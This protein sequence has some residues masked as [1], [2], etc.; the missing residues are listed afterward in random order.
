MGEIKTLE[1]LLLLED[2]FTLKGEVFAGEGETCGEV[3]FNTSMAGYQEAITDP[4][5]HGQILTFTYPH[6]GNYGCNPYDNE[7]AIPQVKG[8]L[9]KRHCHLPDHPLSEEKLGDFLDR[10]GV[11]GVEGIDTRTLTLHLRRF[12]AMKGIIATGNTNKEELSKKLAE[13]PSIVGKNL[14]QNVTTSSPYYRPYYW[15]SSSIK[16]EWEI[17]PTPK[18]SGTNHVVVVDLGVKYSILTALAE[19]G[20]RVTVVPAT[21]P[22]EEIKAMDPSGILFSNGPGDPAPL[23]YITST[24]RSL[25]GWRPIMGI[26]LGHQVI[27]RTLGM[28]SFKLTFGHRGVNHPVKDLQSGRVLITVQNH[29]FNLAYNKDEDLPEGTTATHVNLNDNTLE[30]IENLN[31]GLFS[32]Q[33]HPEAGPGPH[34]CKNLFDKFM[35]ML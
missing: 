5:Y 14:V 30:G 31:W 24:V 35:E 7:S 16:P 13:Y 10:H 4:S 25:L 15:S 6:I 8:V 17:T 21:T 32:V 34:D 18:E 1:A 3:V 27:G 29:G 33:F 9:V 23:D 19:R 11:I 22:V 20:C 28:E 2:G 12:G 26:C